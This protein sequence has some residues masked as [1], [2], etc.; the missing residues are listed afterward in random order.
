MAKES[1]LGALNFLR[2]AV[3]NL[4]GRFQAP[5][6]PRTIPK[7]RGSE[8]LLVFLVFFC[9]PDN[10]GAEQWGR[11]LPSAVPGKQERLENPRLS[12]GCVFPGAAPAFRGYGKHINLCIPEETPRNSD[13][14]YAQINHSCPGNRAGFFPGISSAGEGR[15]IPGWKREL[16]E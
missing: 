13:G 7:P 3:W 6:R 12:L 10:L 1:R 14:F 5:G 16:R 11:S 8:T 2:R 15:S 4:L 9:P